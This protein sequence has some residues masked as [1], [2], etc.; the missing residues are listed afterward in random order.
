MKEKILGYIKKKFNLDEATFLYILAGIVIVVAL[1]LAGWFGYGYV[2][3][4]VRG[5]GNGGAARELPVQDGT[6]KNCKFRR[7]LDGICV[8]SENK[9][10]PKLVA[11][12]IENHPDARPQ[13]G[14][15]QASIVYEAPVEA[16]YTRF[17]AIYPL[18]E[19]FLKV[20]PVR[21]ARPYYLD[22]LSEYHDIMYMHVGGSPDALQR[23][24]EY[25]IFDLNEF[26]RGQYYW[27]VD[28]RYAP[29]NVY[30]SSRLWEQA[31]VD[32]GTDEERGMRNEEKGN[33]KFED[34]E[35]C[36][37]DCVNEITI[38]FLPPTYEAV[39]KFNTSTDKYERYQ[40]GYPHTDKDGFIIEADNVVVIHTTTRVLDSIGRIAMDTIGEGDAIVFRDGYMIRGTWKK[41]MRESKT[42]WYDSEGNEISL[43]PGKTWIEVL[44]Q[45][46]ELKFENRN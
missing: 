34:R 9:T 38:S 44:N 15:S 25:N 1:L 45:N 16:N 31:W 43:K 12:M 26:Y 36:S 40:M 7:I 4:H 22:W 10:N 18:G 17:M 20:G 32:Y 27:R 14:L 24:T 39:W 41:E 5:A 28:D 8:D 19:E 33:W 6:E 3:N 30:T 13:S 29:H 35:Q 23:I 42:K 11:V 46:A 2:K 21:S 37:E